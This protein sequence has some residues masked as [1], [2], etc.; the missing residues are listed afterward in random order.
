MTARRE[1]ETKRE[2]ARM[3]QDVH[4]KEGKKGVRHLKKKKKSTGA[5]GRERVKHME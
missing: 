5:R 3:E 1:K 2:G 4:R